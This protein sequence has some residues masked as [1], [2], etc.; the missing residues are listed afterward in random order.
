MNSFN[1]NIEDYTINDF[2]EIFD[3]T[4]EYTHKQLNNQY[5]K[6]IDTIKKDKTINDEKKEKLNDFFTKS[7]NILTN[8]KVG[9]NLN[10]S[11]GLVKN[12]QIR[13]DFLENLTKYNN[14]ITSNN[15][16]YLL[17]NDVEGFIENDRLPKY[18]KA[19]DLG[20]IQNKTK[21]LTYLMNI[22][23]KF[24]KNYYTTNTSNFTIDIPYKLSNV[25]SMQL[26]SI[27]LPNSW[28]LFDETKKTNIFY[29]QSPDIDGNGNN[30]YR[31]RIE[32]G[33]YDVGSFKENLIYEKFNGVSFDPDL[34]FPLE[35]SVNNFNGKTTIKHVGNSNPNFT[36]DF[37]IENR[38]SPFNMGWSLG[39]RMNKYTGETSYT[40]EAIYNAGSQ[41]YLFFIVKDFQNHTNDK[42]IAIF[43]KSYLAKD[44]LAK[45]PLSAS[46]FTILFEEQ[47]NTARKREYLSPVDINRL[48]FEII[49]EY[50]DLINLNNMDFSVTLQFEC[51]YDHD[52]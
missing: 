48:E 2:I 11:L 26:R 3:L 28:Y 35:I 38:D 14:N 46:S 33:N 30:L 22:D 15:E 39:Y 43:Q 29:A 47:N 50:G 51:L 37:S 45:I 7:R 1:L 52:K 19:K 9:N 31:V 42:I 13:S 44:I 36:L 10:D 5:L 20:I 4:N 32:S 40:S 34:Q 8:I 17:N 41:K 27:E 25:I 18:E 23:S 21:T 6:L 12:S 16:S 49:D 24:R